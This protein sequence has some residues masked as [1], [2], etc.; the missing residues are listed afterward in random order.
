MN[1]LSPIR[2]VTVE[3]VNKTD[4]A[5]HAWYTKNHTSKIVFNM[6][7]DKHAPEKLDSFLSDKTHII[8][9]QFIEYGG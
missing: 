4:C 1:N 7:E 9:S 6:G 2:Q 5:I 3:Y 8:V